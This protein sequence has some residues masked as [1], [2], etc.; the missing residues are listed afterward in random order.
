MAMTGGTGG[1]VP[2]TVHDAL[3]VRGW[4]VR[5]AS[6]RGEKHP[7]EQTPR[8]DAY[9]VRHGNGRIAVVV[10]DGLG[11]MDHSHLAARA[12]CNALAE[13]LLTARLEVSEDWT[14]HLRIASLA[15]TRAAALVLG[16]RA[17]NLD[18]VADVMATTATAVVVEGLEGDAPWL[19]HTVTV[20]DSSAWWRRTRVGPL[21]FEPWLL[22]SGGRLSRREVETS[23]ALALPLPDDAVVIGASFEIGPEELILVCTDGVADAFEG[24]GSGVAASFATGWN[25][26]PRL[27]DLADRIAF[28]TGH[29]AGDR[30]AVAVW[31]PR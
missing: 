11:A 5:A 19:A 6:R 2:D 30:T 14:A 26:P 15:V 7:S 29:P 23:R 1:V 9:A 3:D 8:Q 25:T 10:C 12:A 28:D 21:R 27:T 13:H 31:T 18:Q 4:T 20:G 17:P 22:M 24:G 16:N